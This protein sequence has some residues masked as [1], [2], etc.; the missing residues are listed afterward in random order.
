M[1]EYDKKKLT[2]IKS[3]SFDDVVESENYRYKDMKYG[4]AEGLAVTDEFIYVVLDNNKDS[5]EHENN[6]NSL[7]IKNR[8]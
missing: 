3:W 7:F 4:L 5:R 2:P 1:F 6:Q 8:K